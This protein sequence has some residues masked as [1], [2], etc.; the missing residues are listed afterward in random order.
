MCKYKQLA[1]VIVSVFVG[2][3]LQNCTLLHLYFPSVRPVD[4]LL[5]QLAH[6]GLI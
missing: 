4:Q 2:L 3:H 5:R 1:D 6:K